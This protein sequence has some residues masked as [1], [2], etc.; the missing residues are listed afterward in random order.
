MDI[1]LFS[2]GV[3]RAAD[4]DIIAQ[5]ARQAEAVGFDSIWAPE[6]VVLFD[7]AAYTSQ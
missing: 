5:V 7:D 2:I 3:G 4:P 6:H 1:G